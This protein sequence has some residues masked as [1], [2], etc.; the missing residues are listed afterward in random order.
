MSH[1][2]AKRKRHPDGNAGMIR[3]A[4]QEAKSMLARAY[5]RSLNNEQS[6]NIQDR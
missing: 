2:Q 1:K 5:Q 3:R 6:V 4:Q